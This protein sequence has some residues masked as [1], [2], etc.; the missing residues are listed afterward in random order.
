MDGCNCVLERSPAGFPRKKFPPTS[1]TAPAA[2]GRGQGAACGVVES[3]P[4]FIDHDVYFVTIVLRVGGGRILDVTRL[5]ARDGLQL[6]PFHDPC[7]QRQLKYF[8]HNGGKHG[9]RDETREKRQTTKKRQHGHANDQSNE[10]V[11]PE[12]AVHIISLGRVI[13]SLFEKVATS[14]AKKRCAQKS[15]QEKKERKKKFPVRNRQEV[16]TK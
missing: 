13:R 16:G 4:D 14:K 1:K 12:T 2:D 5:L 10:I 9:S 7:S 15:G 8:P 3:A 11:V 6:Q